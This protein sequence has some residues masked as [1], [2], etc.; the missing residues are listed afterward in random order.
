MHFVSRWHDCLHLSE[1]DF[2]NLRLSLNYRQLDVASLETILH[3]GLPSIALINLVTSSSILQRGFLKRQTLNTNRYYNVAY[4]IILAAQL[5][6]P[7]DY[8]VD[9]LQPRV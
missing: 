9:R 4:G 3:W 2:P 1:T 5:S 6:M 7:W 8:V